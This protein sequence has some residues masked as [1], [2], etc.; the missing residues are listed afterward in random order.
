MSPAYYFATFLQG[1]RVTEAFEKYEAEF[2][3]KN[4]IYGVTALLI[5]V[6]TLLLL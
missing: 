2:R 5:F 4:I 3:I 1:L 6:P